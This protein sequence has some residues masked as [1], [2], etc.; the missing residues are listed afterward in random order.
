MKNLKYEWFKGDRPGQRVEMDM[1]ELVIIFPHEDILTLWHEMRKG[2]VYEKNGV[3]Y[4][5][6]ELS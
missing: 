4:W 5:A 3:K 2:K 1:R 6:E